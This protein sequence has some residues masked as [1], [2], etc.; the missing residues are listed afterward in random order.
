M[1]HN[2]RY[3]TTLIIMLSFALG[4]WAEPTVNIIKQLNGTA[5]D[6]AGTASAAIADRTCTLT[7][8][9]ANGNY[10][11]AEFITAYSTVP[12]SSANIRTRAPQLDNALIEITPRDEKPNPSGETK[13]SFEMP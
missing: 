12:G 7:V 8:T 4:A 9:P 2:A 13:Y 5:N 3:V 1:K 10:V 6:A 11:T